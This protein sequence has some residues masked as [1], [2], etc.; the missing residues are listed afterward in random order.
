M[1]CGLLVNVYRS[2]FF[3]KRLKDTLYSM[4]KLLNEIQTGNLKLWMYCRLLYVVLYTSHSCRSLCGQGWEE[5]RRWCC[6]WVMAAMPHH[7]ERAGG[8][9]GRSSA[10][11]LCLSLPPPPQRTGENHLIRSSLDSRLFC[12]FPLRPSLLPICHLVFL[13]FVVL[14]PFSFYF[15]FFK[16][17]SITPSW[18]SWDFSAIGNHLLLLGCIHI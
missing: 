4:Q 12:L 3:G 8:G 11:P 10:G 15:Q 9:G 6:A 18:S 1:S 17:I 14:I 5:L 16:L 13:L 2:G 7:A